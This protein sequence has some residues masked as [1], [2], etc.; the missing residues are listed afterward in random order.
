[1]R[2][3]TRQELALYD[4]RIGRLYIAYN[5]RVYDVSR[6]FHWRTG[7]H[8]FRHRAGSDLT[9]AMPQAPHGAD[10]LDGFPIIGTL[11]D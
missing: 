6:S 3:F 9:A 2:E 7:R 11:V 1:M 10:K 5:G 8:H 4:G